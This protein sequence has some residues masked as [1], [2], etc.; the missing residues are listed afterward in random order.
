MIKVLK[1][2]NK[3]DCKVCGSKLAFEPEDVEDK[4]KITHCTDGKLEEHTYYI[5]C[6]ICKAKF[7]IGTTLFDH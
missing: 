3:V 6:P 2:R 4:C 1:K 5:T 7:K